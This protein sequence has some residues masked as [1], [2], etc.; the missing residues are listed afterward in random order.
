MEDHFLHFRSSDPG[1]ED[2]KWR[3]WSGNKAVLSMSDKKGRALLAM[4]DKKAMENSQGTA[5]YVGQKSD[6]QG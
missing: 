5:G 2:R 1:K 3:K 6:S 4:S